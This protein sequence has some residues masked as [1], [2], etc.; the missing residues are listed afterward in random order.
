M[1]KILNQAT[2]KPALWSEYTAEVLW[3][4]PHIATQMLGF[5][6]N[7][8]LA[9]ASRTHHFIEDSVKW[10][11]DEFK[12]NHTSRAIDFGCGPG[13]YT[14]R[15]KAQGVGTV[16]GLDFSQNSLRYAEEQARLANLDITYHLG[17]YLDYQDSRQFDL[18]TMVMCD[19]CALNPAQR[20]ELIGKFKMLLAK[21]GHIALDV[22]TQS[23]FIKQKESVNLEKNAMNG[24]WSNQDYWCLQSSFTYQDESVTLD[25]YVIYQDNKEWSVFNWLQHFTLDSLNKELNKH[26]LEVKAYYSDLRGT[27]YQEGDELAVVISHK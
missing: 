3:A 18:I 24:F 25:K 12:L 27:P 19:L 10:L 14:Q 22:Y 13:L 16:V 17:N 26:D 20:S 2:T 15:L 11:H 21:E 8:D 7:P 1:F 23:R 5:H 6:L 4:D 9:L